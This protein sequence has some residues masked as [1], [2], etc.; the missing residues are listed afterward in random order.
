MMP[1]N[2]NDRTVFHIDN[3]LKIP[4]FSDRLILNV[5]KKCRGL[6]KRGLKKSTSFDENNPVNLRWCFCYF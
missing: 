2:N 6:N 4:F 5:K 3:Y 1:M